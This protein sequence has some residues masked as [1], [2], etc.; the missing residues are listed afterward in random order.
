VADF[1]SHRWR[2][3]DA[4]I[5][6]VRSTPRHFTHSKMMCWVALDRADRLAARGLLPSNRRQHWRQ[7]AAGC[8]RFIE[9]HCFSPTLGS[10]TRSAGSDEL[11]ASVLLGLLSGYGQNQ[12]QRWR[13]TVDAIRRRLGHGDFVRRYTGD[14]GVTGDEGAF[15]ACSF[16]LAES[17]A[18][19][20][21]APDAAALLDR[22]VAVTNDVGLLAEEVDPNTGAFLGNLPQGLSHLALV[23]AAIEVSVRLDAS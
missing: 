19:T 22:L 23:S 4:G 14:D 10:Y 9:Q 2:E 8:A 11:D 1:I 17:L 21:S 15:I 5:W 3:R 12:P 20:G 7:E 18:R 6:E 16:W 13:G